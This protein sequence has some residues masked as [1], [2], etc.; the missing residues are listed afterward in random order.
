MH[1]MVAY[2]LPKAGTA[3]SD[4]EDGAAYS[5]STG[6]F[7]VA[8][9]ASSGADSREWAYTLTKS[10][11][12]DRPAAVFDSAAVQPFVEWLDKTRARFD[13]HAP[14]FPVSRM[15]DWVQA[16]GQRTGAHA[17]FLGGRVTSNR[18]QAV[19]IGDCCL[20]QIGSRGGA[21][22]F[23]LTSANQFTSA[24]ELLRSVPAA[25]HRLAA[26]LRWYSTALSPRDVLFAASDA[27]AQWLVRHLEDAELLRGLITIGMRG[28]GL[29]CERLRESG[30]M[31]NDDVT[32]W[33]ARPRSAGGR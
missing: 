20:V 24:P 21:T 17:A 25:D 11:V 9:G 10:F 26:Q 16:A 1:E 2:W 8:D 30:E 5:P 6:W 3:A 31:N 32:F 15:P 18:V 33:R 4:W 28:F 14:E 29:L 27:F 13:P 23:P 19:A 22:A 7:A 12:D